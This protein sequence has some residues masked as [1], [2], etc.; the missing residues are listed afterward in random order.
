MGSLQDSHAVTL[1]KRVSRITPDLHII[2]VLKYSTHE[3]YAH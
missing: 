3:S 2:T 1:I